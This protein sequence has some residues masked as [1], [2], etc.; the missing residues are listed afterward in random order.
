MSKKRN[1]VS[2]W[3]GLDLLG[4]EMLK[5][6]I[7]WAL[8]PGSAVEAA[9]TAAPPNTP[10][11]GGEALRGTG[12]FGTNLP[13]KYA[14]GVSGT[15]LVPFLASRI[16]VARAVFAS[17]SSCQPSFVTLER[18]FCF[19]SYGIACSCVLCFLLK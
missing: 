15:C 13:N 16:Y 17:I 5:R 9:L 1:I 2:L 12:D 11:H 6:F 4:K 18:S 7:R 19:L 8:P 10:H 3:S 14:L